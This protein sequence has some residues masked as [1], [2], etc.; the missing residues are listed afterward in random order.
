MKEG[1]LVRN[2]YGNIFAGTGIVVSNK[3]RWSALLGTYYQIYIPK[4]SRTIWG[5]ERE[6]EVVSESR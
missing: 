2:T 5:H 4:E 3:T 1:D 6:W